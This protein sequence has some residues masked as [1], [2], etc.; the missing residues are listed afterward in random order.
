MVHPIIATAREA[1]LDAQI[2]KA[3]Q[4]DEWDQ[5]SITKSYHRLRV[6]ELPK[7]FDSFPDDKQRS[8]KNKLKVDAIRVQKSRDRLATSERNKN[9]VGRN[10][11]R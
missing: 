8:V 5:E 10:D 2:R 7:Y 4:E 6:E 11:G 1:A 3:E 9:L